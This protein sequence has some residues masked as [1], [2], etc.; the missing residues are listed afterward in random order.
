MLVTLQAQRTNSVVLSGFADNIENKL[1]YCVSAFMLPGTKCPT[2][3]HK[4]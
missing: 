1:R 4:L 2:N 3:R